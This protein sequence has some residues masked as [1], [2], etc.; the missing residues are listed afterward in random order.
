MCMFKHRNIIIHI[1][2]IFEWNS[3]YTNIVVI[4]LLHMYFLVVR[5]Y[6][7]VGILILATP[8]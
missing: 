4:Y 3:K 2:Y 5:D 8:R 1:Y 6:T 7:R